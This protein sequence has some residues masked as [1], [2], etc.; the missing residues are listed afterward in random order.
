MKTSY[1]LFLEM[2]KLTN[3]TD[4]WNFVYKNRYNP[5]MGKVLCDNDMT[6]IEF[7]VLDE[8]DEPLTID[9]EYYI[10]YADGIFEL[11]NALGIEAEPV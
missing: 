11:F 9:F 3:D 8:D 4:R 1:E 5:S 2:D 10:G 7:D 6:W